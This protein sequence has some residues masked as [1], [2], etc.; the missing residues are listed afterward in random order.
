M[1]RCSRV[2]HAEMGH[3]AGGVLVQG[4]G[5]VGLYGKFSKSR[6][7]YWSLFANFQGPLLKN[8]TGKVAH[9]GVTN[10]SRAPLPVGA[11]LSNLL[12]V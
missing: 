4:A 9:L 10:T 7:Y 1:G 3:L 5:K 6:I 8:G 11:V 12:R 2:R